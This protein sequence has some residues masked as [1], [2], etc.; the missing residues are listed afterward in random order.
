LIAFVAFIYPPASAITSLCSLGCDSKKTTMM[1]NRSSR[2]A[3]TSSN[4]LNEEA[5]VPGSVR[6]FVVVLS[7]DD[8]DDASSFCSSVSGSIDISGHSVSDH[9]HRLL[10]LPGPPISTPPPPLGTPS[11]QLSTPSPRRKARSHPPKG[12][13]MKQKDRQLSISTTT[14]DYSYASESRWDCASTKDCMPAVSPGIHRK[15]PATVC[16]PKGIKSR[17]V[18]IL[19]SSLL[20]SRSRSL[21][22]SPKPPSQIKKSVCQE[23]EQLTKH[24]YNI[25]YSSP[26]DQDTVDI[27]LATLSSSPSLNSNS[28]QTQKYVNEAL[29]IVKDG[30]Q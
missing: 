24:V 14:S 6:D 10:P 28:S 26:G 21:A 11:P 8:Y 18:P 29:A 4:M 17:D 2:T 20:A 25:S 30:Q 19:T 27:T 15:R 16:S 3:S 23:D 12:P 22:L 5:E 1:K 13:Q 7:E 9:F